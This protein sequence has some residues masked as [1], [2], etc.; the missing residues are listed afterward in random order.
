MCIKRNKIEEK[1]TILLLSTSTL[2]YDILKYY[3]KF[4]LYNMIKF[5][6]FD[7][8]IWVSISYGFEQKS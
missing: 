1:W 3:L 4:G 6:C 7:L 2:F 8:R 5:L